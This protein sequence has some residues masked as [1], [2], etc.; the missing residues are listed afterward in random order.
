MT[1]TNDPF[2]DFISG[3]DFAGGD[4]PPWQPEE[5]T[6]KEFISRLDIALSEDP[7]LISQIPA[8]LDMPVLDQALIAMHDTATALGEDGVPQECIK[9][10]L[11]MRCALYILHQQN[12]NFLGMAEPDMYV[13]SAAG[14]HQLAH[15]FLAIAYFYLKQEWLDTDDS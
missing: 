9:A 7:S 13:L 5:E 12:P 10:E 1:N 6:L 14:I 8:L 15:N 3:L 2:A 4:V 11:F